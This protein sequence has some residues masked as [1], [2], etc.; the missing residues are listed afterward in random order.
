MI[1]V[2]DDFAAETI[3]RDG[4]AGRRWIEALPSIVAEVCARWDLSIDGEV[5]HGYLAVV[6]PVRSASDAYVLKVTWVDEEN[7]HEA[8]ALAT[9]KGNGAVRLVDHDDRLHAM[10]LER[11]DSE[12][13][14][15]SVPIDEA[16]TVAATLL[17]RLCVPAPAALRS[18]RDVAERWTGDLVERWE[19][20]DRRLP[21]A[22]VD[23]A[24][25]ASARLGP[26]SADLLV[27]RDLHYGN[28]LRG[29]REPWLVIDPKPLRGD[30][31]FAVAP[32]LWTRFDVADGAEAVRRR[33]DAI[34][35]GA[36]LDVE[37]ARGWALTYAVAD[38]L[39]SLSMGFSDGAERCALIA[40][41]LA[42]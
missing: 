4:E 38:R 7:E 23:A 30:P 33:F 3:A 40:V 39:W 29:A 25:D 32:L 41:S 6:V 15:E 24:V 34:V 8:L 35:A 5:M 2:P 22:I 18:V 12:V 19:R 27:N 16:V 17:R 13:T 37:R 21:R 20:Y 42:R 26:S 1:R 31:E 14:L 9:W 28:V 36:A 10:L 11:L